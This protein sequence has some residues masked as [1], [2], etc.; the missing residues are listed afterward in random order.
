MCLHMAIHLFLITIL[1]GRY[2]VS[3]T[4]M[5]NCGTKSLSDLSQVTTKVAELG[6]ELKAV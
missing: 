3:I 5:K 4:E 1:R 6:F 2:S